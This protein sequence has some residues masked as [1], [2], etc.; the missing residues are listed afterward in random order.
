MKEALRPPSGS[1]IIRGWGDFGIVSIQSLRRGW[2]TLRHDAASAGTRRGEILLLARPAGTP[3]SRASKQVQQGRTA[4]GKRGRRTRF[5][6]RCHLGI[7]G[8]AG[9]S[10]RIGISSP[11][12]LPGCPRCIAGCT[13]C[14]Q[15]ICSRSICSQIS[16]R[17]GVR[18]SC[19]GRPCVWT[20]A[21]VAAD[22][23]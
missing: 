21:S 5:R 10:K 3:L 18:D 4:D 14:S 23:G 7:S 22:G 2:T 8:G 9:C 1:P 17:P 12:R 13:R 20:A 11:S 6:N 15:S 19:A 16:S